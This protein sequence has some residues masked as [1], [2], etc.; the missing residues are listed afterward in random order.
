MTAQAGRIGRRSLLGAAALTGAAGLFGCGASHSATSPAPPDLVPVLTPAADVASLLGLDRFVVAHRGSGD[1]WPEHTLTAYQAGLAAGAHAVEISVR[2]TADNQLVCHHDADFVRTSGTAG[3]V[4]ETKF[5]GLPRVDAR[6]WLGPA[7]ELEPISL[8]SDVL[9]ELPPTALAFVED[10]DGTNTSQLLELLDAQPRAAER[11]VWKQWGIAKQAQVARQRG[12]HAWGYFGRDDVDRM[13][14]FAE[15]YD[16]LGVPVDLPDSALRLATAHGK[17]VMAWAVH[18]RSQAARLAEHGVAGL[19]CANVPY[20]IGTP[21]PA[22]I[23]TFDTGRRAAGDLPRGA[24][25]SWQRQPS[26]VD[27][28]LRFTDTSASSYLLG[29]LCPLPKQC[30]LS[31][32]VGW[33]GEPGGSIGIAFGL[34][35]DADYAPGSERNPAG[36]HRVGL[37]S[38]G[39]LA[40]W[41]DPA[42]SETRRVRIAEPSNAATNGSALL[43]VWLD[44]RSWTVRL[45][46]GAELQFPRTHTGGYLWAWAD[47]P[48]SAG[49]VTELRID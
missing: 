34:P 15:S 36:A 1:N 41:E 11:F 45:G 6:R 28:G 24:S 13:A 19:M 10:K 33:P 38:E 26:L 12:Y 40:V 48:G 46:N 43:Q 20:V 14:E 35:D 37:T 30:M 3:R 5:A 22:T 18:T 9:A 29:S 32:R 2:A 21:R 44:E 7:T 17:P 47:R 27:Q 23:D 49:S 16:C 8:L 39:R 4:D 25:D 31:I 42:G